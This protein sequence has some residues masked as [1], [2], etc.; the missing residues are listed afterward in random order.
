M[1]KICSSVIL[2]FLLIF[3]L[4]AEIPESLYGI[5]E[6]KD[7]IVFFEN[8]QS[9][10]NEIV[11]ILKEYYGWYYDRA[12]EPSAYAD[13][14]KRIR[15]TGTTRNAEHIGFSINKISN[16]ENTNAYEI[17]LE[18]SKSQNTKIPVYIIKDNMFLNFYIQ[19]T[20]N[21]SFYR[22][23]AVREGVKVS[24]YKIPQN[25]SCLYINED[26]YFDIRYWYTDMD[27]EK[28]YVKLN[29][30]DKSYDVDK[31]IFSSGN[32]YSCVSGRSKKIRNVVDPFQ[33]DDSTFNYQE[34]KSVIIMDSEPYLTKIADK[35]TFEDLME[36]VI[37]ANKR[38]KPDPAPIFP[39][40]D[41]NWHW[42]IID[43]L[44]ANNQLI[45]EVRAR[46]QTFGPRAKD[47]NR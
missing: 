13:K 4:S 31:H 42:D 41:L 39:P 8:T 32:N 15:N 35:K 12:V 38:R 27:Y 7:R 34:N 44:E 28:A 17:N 19:D 40:D 18:F 21:P 1:R 47:I 45:Q 30:Q 43:M 11:I 37:T 46:Q 25:I 10:K 29:Y 14:E 5:W 6:G 26:S 20:T 23:N 16:T 24:D 22:G 3:Y 36:I 2:L 9:E 33:F